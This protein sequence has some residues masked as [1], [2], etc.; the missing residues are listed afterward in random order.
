MIEVPRE[1]IILAY[2]REG[3]DVT[4]YVRLAAGLILQ[5]FKEVTFTTMLTHLARAISAHPQYG[6]VFQRLDHPRLVPSVLDA[7]T[8]ELFRVD[9]VA[10]IQSL[11]FETSALPQ[12]PPKVPTNA[13][14]VGYD[15]LAEAFGDMTFFRIVRDSIE[16]PGCGQLAVFRKAA[17]RDGYAIFKCRK[18]CPEH[19]PLL[20]MDL[21]E[22]WLFLPTSRLLQ[23]PLD[24]FFLPLIWNTGAWITRQDLEHKYKA[25]MAEKETAC[26]KPLLPSVPMA[27]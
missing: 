12:K 5:E 14:R 4:G 24:Q 27:F 18:A 26:F 3:N 8:V 7:A 19:I 1:N 15:T 23:Q 6:V 13:L 2:Q 9:P 10:A 20:V 11:T 22:Q 25:Y 21:T 16:C 17:E